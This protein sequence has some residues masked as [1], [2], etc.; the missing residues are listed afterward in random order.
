MYTAEASEP[1]RP[2]VCD[3]RYLTEYRTS[4]EAEQWVTAVRLN[5]AGFPMNE[6]VR[7]QVHSRLPHVVAGSPWQVPS[8]AYSALS[9]LSLWL[10]LL[11]TASFSLAY[12]KPVR[13]V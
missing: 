13:G 2:V 9:S 8:P 3:Y 4:I 6:G 1:T 5:A 10:I 7:E 11:L 12:L